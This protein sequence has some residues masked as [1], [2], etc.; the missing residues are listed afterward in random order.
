MFR[1]TN[2]EA[3]RKALGGGQRGIPHLD[4]GR[5][6]KPYLRTQERQG[7]ECHYMQLDRMSKKLFPHLD[8]GRSG[9]PQLRN[10]EG[11][12][13]YAQLNKTSRKLLLYLESKNTQLKVTL[14]YDFSITLP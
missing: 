14:R 12:C 9:K 11:E 7:G 1:L 13:H 5:G 2:A 10:Q 8:T 6:G 3:G 4:T